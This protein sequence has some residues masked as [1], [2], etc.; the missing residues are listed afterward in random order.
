MLA[1]GF[2]LLNLF[3]GII[4]IIVGFLLFEALILAIRILFEGLDIGCGCL[5]IVFIGFIIL[6][7]LG[8]I[9]L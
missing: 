8:L 1:I 5:G 9:F 4:L 7:I 2:L 3:V 6:I